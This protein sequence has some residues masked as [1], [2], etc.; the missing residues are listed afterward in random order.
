MTYVWRI[1]GM[2]GIALGGCQSSASS[3]V[4]SSDTPVIQPFLVSQPTAHDTDDPAIW[5]HPK[6][7]AQSLVIGTDK[8][9]DGALYV[10]NLQG[11]I[12][13]ENVVRG[14]QRPNNVDVEYDVRLG[15]TLIDIAVVTERLREQV[16]IFRL[17]DM[18]PVDGGGLPVFEGESEAERRAPMGIA[19]YRRPTDGRT[20]LM[21]GRK[22][23]PPE[24]YLWQYELLGEQPDAFSHRLVRQ[25]GA[26]SGAK[27]IEA[28][29][30]DDVHGHVYYAD[31]SFGLRQ[32][33]ADPDSPGTQLSA[34]GQQGFTGDREGISIY[35]PT[36]SSG[37]LLVSDQQAA[38]FE[39]FDR[40]GPEH[41]HVATLR[42]ATQE[43]DGSE[44]EVTP[45][46]RQFAQGLFV[47]MSDDRT[48]QFYRWEDL[49]AEIDRQLA[50]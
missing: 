26:F 4:V 13:A 22:T 2:L 46:G 23:G 30:V 18:Q 6:D 45:L 20:F 31:E 17:P 34:F 39:V 47:A 10:F 16:R 38:E 42:L 24:G 32:Y 1:L 36:D 43:S 48:F 33:H 7:P 19:I 21:V 29:D 12:V 35:A 9:A 15:D 40:I 8:D 5:I 14:L 28:I 41:A 44:V 25:F 49:Q 11:Q 27:E 3:G 50:Q 37:Y